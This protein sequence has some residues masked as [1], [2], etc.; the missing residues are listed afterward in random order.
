[1]EQRT[2]RNLVLSILGIILII[3]LSLKLGV[4][5][6][7]NLSLF[8]SGSKNNEESKIQKT[9]FIAPPVLNSFPEATA[10]ANIVISGIASKKQTIN[11]YINDEL[12]DTD[13]ADDNGKFSF[14]EVIRPGENTI[15]AKAIVNNK[16]SDFSNTIVVSFKN[17]PPSLNITSPSENQSFSK[18]QNTA[19]IK[20]ATDA[21]VKV[22]I[23]GLWAIVDDS[24]NFSYMLPLQNGENKIRISASDIAGN[25][26]EKEI[27]VTY[28]P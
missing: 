1:M 27:K 11:L 9:A 26:N 17:A 19:E 24:G 3:F 20:G 13:T 14:E 12:S 25:K 10:S 18:D 16:E 21:D 7:A 6:L 23:N 4:P 5:F 2:K 28:S 22:T 15:K 8:L